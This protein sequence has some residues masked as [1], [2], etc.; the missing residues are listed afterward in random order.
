VSIEEALRRLAVAPKAGLDAAQAQRRVAQ[1]GA[2]QISPPPRRLLL[3]IAGWVFGGFGSLLLVASIVCFLAWYD[4]PPL[5]PL[6]PS[7]F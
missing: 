5:S 2:N 4:V 6:L 3:K 7:R 1:F